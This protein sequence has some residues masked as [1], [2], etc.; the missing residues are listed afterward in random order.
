MRRRYNEYRSTRR[1]RNRDHKPRS[2][3]MRPGVQLA[4][5]A[6]AALIVYVILQ[7]GGK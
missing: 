2:M 3:M 1:R 6:I 7:S 4:L 5:L